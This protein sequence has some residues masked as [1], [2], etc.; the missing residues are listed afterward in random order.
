[1]LQ[2]IYLLAL[3]LQN[4]VCV[5]YQSI[6]SPIQTCLPCSN[7]SANP[8]FLLVLCSLFLFLSPL[9]CCAR[10]LLMCAVLTPDRLQCKVLSNYRV[11]VHLVFICLPTGLHPPIED[12]CLPVL[13]LT[14]TCIRTC[15]SFQRKSSKSCGLPRKVMRALLKKYGNQGE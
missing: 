6:V 3:R 5:N 12:F 4:D 8:L 10:T 11:C 9:L 7:V 13:S 14:L 2:L 1:M 15:I